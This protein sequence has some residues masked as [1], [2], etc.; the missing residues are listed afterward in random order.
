MN[1]NA[2]STLIFI[3]GLLHLAIT[4]AGL[5]MTRVLDWRHA[6][7]P[8]KA[9]TRHIIW[10]HAAFVWLNLVAFGVISIILPARLTS[11]DPVSRAVCGFIAAFWGLRLLVGF[12]FFDARP[13]LT[14]GML[15]IAYHALTAVIA[16]FVF[17]YAAAALVGV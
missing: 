7:A 1:A 15:T 17:C 3:A 13:H 2:L 12:L 5:T 9:L 8:L 4:S 11:G 14:S 10:T 6:L 16:F